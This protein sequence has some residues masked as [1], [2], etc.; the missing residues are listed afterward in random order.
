MNSTMYWRCCWLLLAADDIIGANL[1]GACSVDE[2]H[3]LAAWF[4]SHMA[5]CLP[6]GCSSLA[7]AQEANIGPGLSGRAALGCGCLASQAVFALC[8]LPVACSPPFPLT[9]TLLVLGAA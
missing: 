3:S 1:E 7:L 4:G 2:V 6:C 5:V 8:L 9:L